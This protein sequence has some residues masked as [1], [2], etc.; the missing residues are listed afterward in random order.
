MA[1]TSYKHGVTWRDVPTSIVAPVTA[2]SGIPVIIGASPVFQST[3][4]PF[5][6]Q[7]RVYLNYQEA[8]AEMGYSDDWKSYPV[9]MAIYTYFA[10]FNV[11]PIVVINVLDPGASKFQGA[12]VSDSGFT[13]RNG[14]TG[15]IARDIVPSTV[16][17]KSIVSDEE[18][19]QITYTLGVDYVGA[20]GEDPADN[21]NKFILNAV[22]G[23]RISS[24]EDVPVLVSYTPINAAG[25]NKSDIIGGIDIATGNTKGLESIEDVFPRHGIVPGVLLVPFFSQDP[26]VAAVVSAKAD[27]INGCFRCITL[28]DIDSAIIKMPIDVKMWKDQNNYTEKR[29]GACWPRVGLGERDVWLSVQLG[30][31]IEKTD[32]DNGNIPVETPSNKLLKMNRTLVGEYGNPTEISFSKAYGDMLNGQ[33]ILTTINW[34]GGWKAW[35]SNMS[36][37]PFIT[38]PKDRW[39]PARRMTDF[40]G[41]SL[42]LT[43]FQFVDRPTNRRLIETITDTVNIWLNSLVSSG[44][45]LGARVEFRHDENPDTE[46]IDGHYVFHVFEFFPLPA[47]WIEFKLE[48]DI[49]Y[50]SVL[51]E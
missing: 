27:D 8:V 17:V 31:R 43:I 22:P 26:E 32:V 14:S 13:F 1:V 7:S 4:G 2:D 10:L 51:F 9:S 25:V 29:M 24:T 18:E 16:V 33:G 5:V 38:D 46:M 37:Y 36:C 48:L 50:L 44:N 21:Q 23:G 45:A 35:G 34:I 49:S 3:R 40:V 12:P 11:G 20:W 28:C 30:A 47:E 39:M 15:F 6:N 19:E 41:N 42:V